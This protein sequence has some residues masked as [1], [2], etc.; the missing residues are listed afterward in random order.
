MEIIHTPIEGPSHLSAQ[1]LRD[2]RGYFSRTLDVQVLA[3]VW[4][5]PGEFQTGEPNRG[6]I[7]GVRCGLHCRS[8]TGE[9]KFVRCADGAELD[10]VV[11]ARPESGHLRSRYDLLLDDQVCSQAYIPRGVPP[12]LPAS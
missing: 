9:A 6:P 4:D 12:R 10:V 7:Q 11:D 2:E 8:C 5:R 1:A 3:D